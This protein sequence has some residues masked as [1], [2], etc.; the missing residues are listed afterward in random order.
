METILLATDGSAHA[1]RATQYV[2]RLGT[3]LRD[4]EVVVLNVQPPIHDWQMHGVTRE[5]IAKHHAQ[6][7]EHILARAE[8]LLKIAGVRTHREYRHAEDPGTMIVQVAKEKSATMIVIGSRGMGA[9]AALMLG[10][11]AQRVV[12][13][14]NIPVLIIK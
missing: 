13:Q 11:A 9:I 4:I 5:H 14:S 8:A 1:E 12:Q 6:A 10:S 7:A 2:A 3:V